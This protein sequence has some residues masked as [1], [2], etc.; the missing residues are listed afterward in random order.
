MSFV[1]QGYLNVNPDGAVTGVRILKEDLEKLR[2]A[3]VNV[4]KSLSASKELLGGI[5]QRSHVAAGS[6]ANLGAQ[7]NDIGMMMAAGQSPLMLAIQQG[8]Q[9]SQVLG[10]MGA[11]G[12]VAALGGAFR[13]MISPVS[14]ATIAIV[15]GVAAVG[16]WAIAA[17]RGGE[18][19]RDFADSLDDLVASMDELNA[20]TS[21]YSASGLVELKQKYGEVTD[22]V[23]A[24]VEAQRQQ[25]LAEADSAARGAIEALADEFRIVALAAGETGRT[26]EQ[27]FT[28]MANRLG[29]SKDSARELAAAFHDL[30]AAGDFSDRS[31]AMAR[32]RDVLKGSAV[33]GSELYAA[34][35]DAESTMRQL[36]A[37]A[38]KAGW[39]AGMISEARTLASELWDAARARAAAMAEAT[40]DAA[41]NPTEFGPGSRA[42]SRPERMG[43]EAS[44][45]AI[46]GPAV[47]TRQG[48]AAAAREERDAVADLILS[49]QG[50]VDILREADPVQQE[51]IRLRE[52]MVDATDA[53]RAKIEDLIRAKEREINL[54]Q[55]QKQTWQSLGQIAL[56][57][58][59][60]MDSALDMLLRSLQEGAFLGSGP[61]GGL[62]G[63]QNASGLGGLF[64]M[65]VGGF[66][67]FRAS[68]GSVQP[69]MYYEVGERGRERFYPGV[70]GTIVPTPAMTRANTG[71]AAQFSITVN[72]NGAT[73]DRDLEARAYAG[74][75]RAIEAAFAQYDAE[76]LPLRIREI[77]DQPERIG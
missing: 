66:G 30:R 12:A 67:G 9:I 77:N 22:Q 41:G 20:I 60:D 45:E 29:I 8:T 59:N 5:G 34:L 58:L 74:T 73:G 54:G 50:E 63:G 43:F 42:R 21:V 71:G 4:S 19:A 10:P 32:I 11:Q 38:P 49:L 31:A 3:G 16:Q 47:R 33:A 72:V 35:L 61:L 18:E 56:T 68:G 2:L 14:L 23:L 76:R 48:G 64:G 25:A 15:A 36:A 37:A 1:V 65:I 17:A 52:H 75:S 57:A 27:S 24:L 55:T 39:L 70:A 28:I 26:A 44:E 13:S 62:F 69:G 46:Y 6:V 53:E 7:F 51:L 40:T